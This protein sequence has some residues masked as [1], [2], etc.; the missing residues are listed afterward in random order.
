MAMPEDLTRDTSTAAACTSAGVTAAS[1]PGYELIAEIG[2]GGMGIVFHARDT[3]LNRDVA[4]KMLSERHPADSLPAQRFLNEACITGQLQHPGIP[5]VHQVGTLDDGRPFLAMKLIKGSTLEAIL[6]QRTDPAADRGRLLAIFEAVCQA[7]GYAHAH[8][9]IHR[10]LKPDNVM[11]GSFGEVQVMD[12]G[13]AKVLGEESPATADTVAAG[14]TRAW[15][16]VSP[17]QEAGSYTQAGALVGTPAFIPPEQALGEIDKVNER[18]DVFGLGAVLAVILTGKPPYIGESSESLRVQAARGKLEDCFAR[19]DASNAEPELVA[20]CK[21]CLAFEPADRPADAGAVAAAVA[22]LRAAADERARRAELER[23][24]LEGEQATAAARSAERRKRRRLLIGAA[25][26]LALAAVG[27]LSAVLAMQRQANADLAAKNAELADEQAKVEDAR[28]TAVKEAAAATAARHDL[29]LTLADSYTT[30]GLVAGE[31]NDPAAAALWFAR[32]VRQSKS[33]PE[34]EFHNRVRYRNWAGAAFAP[35][36]ALQPTAPVSDLALHP[37][38]RYLA[39]RSGAR[40]SVWDL[41]RESP[42][43]PPTG[44]ET[45]TALSW[46]PDGGRIALAASDKS[47]S[48]RVGVFEFPSGKVVRERKWDGPV[49]VVRFSPEG[50]TL[51]IGGRVVLVWHPGDD[52][53]TTPELPHPYPVL[54][55]EFAHNGKRL[56]THSGLA[57]RVFDLTGPTAATPIL[58][59]PHIPY[60]NFG[61]GMPPRFADGGRVV[62]TY[63]SHPRV[64]GIDVATGKPRFEHRP[65]NGTTAFAVSPDGQTVWVGQGENG[66]GVD[67]IDVADGS[68]R[69]FTL[70][71]TNVVLSIVCI[72]DGRTVVTGSADRSLCVWDAATGRRRFPPLTHSE[73]VRLVAGTPDS[74]TIASSQGD[75]LVRVWRL[76]AGVP[77]R[78]IDPGGDYTLARFAVGGRY[79]VP[80]SGTS[81]YAEATLTR[82]QLYDPVTGAPAAPAVTPGGVV[83]DADVSPDGGLLVTASAPRWKAGANPGVP[84]LWPTIRVWDVKTG[85]PVGEV[86]KA[87]SEPRSV[88]FLPD[89]GEV[90]VLCAAG[91]VV[92]LDPVGPRLKRTIIQPGMRFDGNQYAVNGRLRYTP[93]DRRILIF[94]PTESAFWVCDPEAGTLSPIGGKNR[95]PAYDVTASPDGRVWV[96]SSTKN[97]TEFFAADGGSEPAPP[98]V[99]PDW[100]FSARFN[101]AGDRL[102]T[103]SRDGVARL[104][105]WRAGKLLVAYRHADE[106]PLAEF[107]P[108]ERFLVTVS[109]DGSLRVWGTATGEPVAPPIPLGGKALSL[110]VTPDGRF[111]VA[112]GFSK[113]VTVADLGGLTMPTYG[114]ADALDLRAELAS[115]QRITPSGGLAYLTTEEWLTR[116]REQRRRNAGEK[117][118]LPE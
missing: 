42:W 55:I 28:N 37:G 83:F 24:R 5:A 90:A 36:A 7:V 97:L 12:W 110:D 38:G 84:L 16:Q 109:Y 61:P 108:D 65:K 101:R 82:L 95:D 77:A 3:A 46:N 14:Q 92:L 100:T 78:T 60:Y 44:F 13:L 99:H 66:R 23:V 81:S 2:R 67:V 79:V 105:D 89:R 51:A 17:T 117:R 6:K 116:W 73:M 8:Q 88:R 41:D 87:P 85:Q 31:R 107:L 91:Q 35:V 18:A 43:V 25:A 49:S 54:A 29:A 70:P 80:T 50:R 48:A 15:T 59:T 40:H 27:G 98:L 102:L 32:A 26:V 68:L 72:P 71:H 21:K 86:I 11:V 103:A 20:L 93:Q 64:R 9:V 33:D 104:W 30:L 39:T 111:A 96:R 63:P 22:G 62:V 56:V 106:I 94:G 113:H 115:N 75:G 118:H 4:V 10:D 69:P 52:Q 74:R 34:R 19:L 112:S 53:L 114:D 45:P 1:A 76:P 58:V 47:G 57:A